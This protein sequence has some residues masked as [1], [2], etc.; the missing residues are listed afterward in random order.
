MDVFVFENMTEGIED[1]GEMIL[2]T[3]KWCN[4][5]NVEMMQT[6]FMFDATEYCNTGAKVVLHKKKSLVLEVG[7]FISF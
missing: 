4:I 3:N 7:V 6:R 1:K 2:E 5:Y